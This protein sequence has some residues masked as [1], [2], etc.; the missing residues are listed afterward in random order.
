MTKAA[1]RRQERERQ[2]R[3]EVNQ[4]PHQQSETQGHQPDSDQITEQLSTSIPHMEPP[5]PYDAPHL[6]RECQN[7]DDRCSG[8]EDHPGCLN[9]GPGR[10]EGCLNYSSGRYGPDYKVSGCMNYDNHDGCMNYNSG[11]RGPLTTDGCMNYDSRDGCMNYRSEGGCMNYESRD[12]CMNY[13]SSKFDV[14]DRN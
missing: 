7:T 5:P 11:E 4:T 1:L 6:P 9:A 10:A 12:G 13:R 14:L 3:H 2:A 8:D